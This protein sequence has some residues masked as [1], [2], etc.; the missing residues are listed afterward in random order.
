M[1]GSWKVWIAWFI[2]LGGLIV[3]AHR[4]GFVRP[5]RKEIEESNEPDETKGIFTYVFT[6]FGFL[7]GIV[8]IYFYFN[9]SEIAS[10]YFNPNI[11]AHWS[12]YA[13]IVKSFPFLLIL[14][15]ASA[16]GMFFEMKKKMSH[17]GLVI[18]HFIGWLAMGFFVMGTILF[19]AISLYALFMFLLPAAYFLLGG[20]GKGGGGGGGKK[21]TF[22]DQAFGNTK[23][24]D[25]HRKRMRERQRKERENE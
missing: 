11:F 5:H 1:F 16:V 2:I 25:E 12:E 8:F 13:P 24:D 14:F 17:I 7:L 19:V 22:L 15:V 18:I 23:A 6:L 10:L 20:F 3:L 9:P 21:E 4:L